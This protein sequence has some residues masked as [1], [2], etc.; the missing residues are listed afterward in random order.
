MSLASPWTEAMMNFVRSCAG[1]SL[2][3][4][5]LQV[6]D[7][8]NGNIL[9]DSQ[10]HI[11]HIDFGFMLSSS[12]GKNLGFET[13]PF[14]VRFN[15]SAFETRNFGVPKTFIGLTEIELKIKQT[16]YGHKCNFTN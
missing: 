16:R 13:S 4:Y 5:L 7:R 8:H 11:V 15:M 12:P 2:V 6:K 10:G 1:Y 3:C 9:L 14:K